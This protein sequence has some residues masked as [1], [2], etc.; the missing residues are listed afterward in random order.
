MK[1]FVNK[2]FEVTKKLYVVFVACFLLTHLTAR[3]SES[4]PAYKLKTTIK[5]DNDSTVNSFIKELLAKKAE[6]HIFHYPN[7]VERFYAQRNF[8][9]AWTNKD[10]DLKQ[11]SEAM[12]LLDCVLQFG[13][14]HADYH[15]DVLTYDRMRNVFEERSKPT[16]RQKAM[17]D[18]MLTDAMITLIN[19]LHYGKLNPIYSASKIDKGEISGFCTEE[20]LMRAMRKSA[21]KDM[22]MNV[23]PRSK[24]YVLMQEYMKL[25]KGQYVDDCYETPEGV[26]R[27]LAINMERLRWI[28]SDEDPAIKINIPAYTLQLIEGDSTYNFKIIVGKPENRTRV[29]KSR[30]NYISSLSA[31]N[32]QGARIFFK[33]PNAYGIQLYG[34]PDQQSFKLKNRALS[35]KNIQVEKAE[36]LASLL[37]KGDQSGQKVSALLHS[38]KSNQSK[39]FGLRNPVPICIYYLTCEI[40]DGLITNYEDVYKNDTALEL[41]YY[42]AKKVPVLKEIKL[43]KN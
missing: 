36:K 13:L 42:G 6:K 18:M 11:T 17:F 31:Q 5:T 12:L 28:D 14:F 9:S 10:R 15:S 35:N 26:V 34:S 40:L 1:L 24:T 41:A 29:L 33:F 19:N 16:I 22:I 32:K 4:S 7:S 23:Q 25:I 27:K 21:L 8:Q 30:V 3:A 2:H 43:K 38:V 39:D 37:L 20:I